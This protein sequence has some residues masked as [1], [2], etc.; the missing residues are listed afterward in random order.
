MKV[1]VLVTQSCPTLCDPMHCSPPGS[2]VHRV[3]QA[4]I[5]EGLAMLFSRGSS[6]ERRD[7]FPTI[8]PGSPTLQAGS[9]TI[10]ILI[11]TKQHCMPDILYSNHCA[12]LILIINLVSWNPLF[13]G[14]RQTIN[15]SR[16]KICTV[17]LKPTPVWWK[18]LLLPLHI[19]S[20]CICGFNQPCIMWYCNT[21]YLLKNN[22]CVSRP[23]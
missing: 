23:M 13:S 15:K 21:M 22:P 14:R 11:F 16:S 4:R 20:S 10:H 2:F 19:C 6:H 7:L 8:K 5:L 17:D 1:K 12:G 18:I 9:Y 3:L